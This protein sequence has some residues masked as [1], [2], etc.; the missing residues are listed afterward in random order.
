MLSTRKHDF[1]GEKNWYGYLHKCPHRL[2][3][4]NPV[5]QY[6]IDFYCARVR[7]VIEIDGSKHYSD[8]AQ[9][10]VRHRTDILSLYKITVLRFSN[11]D[12]NHNFESVCYKIQKA[13]EEK[14]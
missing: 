13:I 3:R 8:D 6:I 14:I 9:K 12:I 5:D 1:T 4:Q 2:L 11:N 10:Y 7:L